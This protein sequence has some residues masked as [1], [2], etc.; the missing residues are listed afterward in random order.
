MSESKYFPGKKGE[1][2][3][4]VQIEDALKSVRQQ[5]EKV[6]GHT[7]KSWA[8]FKERTKQRL[9]ELGASEKQIA[10]IDDI[11]LETNGD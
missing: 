4:K 11:T 10:E 9:K 1:R 7:P 5:A 8:G 3:Q 2:A 6:G